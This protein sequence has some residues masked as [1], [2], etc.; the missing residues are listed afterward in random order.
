MLRH[1]DRSLVQPGLVLGYPTQLVDD[2]R[3]MQIP[4]WVVP[5]PKRSRRTPWVWWRSLWQ[6]S[7]VI[8]QF[9]PDV[10]HAND[11]PSSQAVNVVA[12]RRGVPQVVHIR[13]GI[14]CIDAA[15]WMP[16]GV[17]VIICISQWVRDELGNVQ[18]TSSLHNAQIEVVPDAV[19]WPSQRGESPPQTPSPTAD[20]LAT[21]LDDLS[22][23]AAA[24]SGHEQVRLGFAG[25]LIQSKGLDLVIEAM[26]QLPKDRRPMLLVAGEDT[27]THG[28]YQRQLEALARRCGVADRVRW[29][30]FLDEVSTL[31][32][33]VHAVVCPSRLEPL[34]LVPLEASQYCLA[35]L[36][37]RVGG[38]AET[39]QDGQTGYLVEPTA[40]AWAGALA[41]LDDTR[42][43]AEMGQAAHERTRRLYSPM[44]YQERLIN[45]YRQLTGA[46][47]VTTATPACRD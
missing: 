33:Q 43:L 28:A 40:Q 26:G 36:A 25:Q 37:N 20:E 6:M 18:S 3:A 2:A 4:Y 14:N 41:R 16:R 24:V 23:S 11:V 46:G 7:R 15:W 47:A 19:D 13:W 42:R 8:K 17:G 38:L 34:G 45:I 5:L 10:T 32:R 9:K 12:G 21:A 31:Y 27:Q 44:V 39:I 35:T 22:Q 29:L 1:L 30:G